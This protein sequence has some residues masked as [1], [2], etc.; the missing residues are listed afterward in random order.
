[1]A[2]VA[3]GTAATALQP[4]GAAIAAQPTATSDVD[5]LRNYGKSKI[6]YPGYVLTD[7]GL[8]YNDLREGDGKAAVKGS[9]VVVDWTG[10]TIG[11]Y[12]R[13]FEATNKT[14]GSAFTGENKEY[15]RFQ[16]GT[17]QVIAGWEEAIIGIKE[18]GIRRIVV[19]EELSYPKDGWDAQGPR[20]S[21]VSGRRTLGFVLQNRG[22]IDA[23][24]L[25]DISLIRID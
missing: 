3:F 8:Q 22:Y 13:P 24:L 4:G 12:G 15:L 21:T 14:K 16:L 5:G 2:A 23:T 11:Y 7:S 20:P 17:D 19:P 6:L 10:Y 1:M 25:F 9:N 18:G